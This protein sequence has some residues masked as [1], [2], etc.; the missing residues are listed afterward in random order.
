MIEPLGARLAFGQDADPLL[1][2]KLAWPA[3]PGKA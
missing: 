3:E 1:R 2:I